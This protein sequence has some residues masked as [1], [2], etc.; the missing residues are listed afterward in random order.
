M[1][2]FS[3]RYREFIRRDPKDDAFINILY[4]AVRSGKTYAMIPKI[5][6]KLNTYKVP[7]KKV[8]FGVSKQTIVNNVLS[9]IFDFVGQGAYSY[10]S[11][12]GKLMLYG[13]EWLVIGAKDEGSEKYVRGMTAGLA[14]GDEGTLIP[15]SFMDMMKSRLSPDGAR[16]YLTT[17]PGSPYHYLK[18]EYIDNPKMQAA[19]DIWA[20]KFLMS[21]NLSLSQAKIE[22]Y[23]RQYTGVFYKLFIKGEWALAENAIYKD[24]LSDNLLYD[25]TTRPITLLNAGGYVEQWIPIDYGT[26]NP[27][28]F[29]QIVD[30]GE[31]YWID[32]E[33]YWASREDGKWQKTDMQICDD[34]K[35]FMSDNRCD[36][37][38][39]VDPSAASLKA[40]MTQMGIWHRNANNDVLDGIRIVSSLLAQKKIRIHR[41]CVRLWG[42]LATYSWDKKNTS[43]GEDKPIKQ[44]DHAPDALR[45]FCQTVV[46]KW[47]I[48]V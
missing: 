11:S 23:E 36:G 33:Y 42:E 10:N 22:Q 46:P 40:Q 47:R 27:T 6:A 26:G 16:M 41:R 13:T 14:Y 43:T 37:Q 29:L 35:L 1:F 38:A 7:G 48:A 30:D 45:Y 34:L 24:S 44:H 4:G 2:A 39:I 18:T 31:T 9:D 25:D 20:Q 15:K 21:D 8:I 28:V 5:I 3:E 12:S 17:N 32:N 19:G